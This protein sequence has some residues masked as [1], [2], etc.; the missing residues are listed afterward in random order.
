MRASFAGGAS[1]LHY[2]SRRRVSWLDID[3]TVS[4]RR[5]DVSQCN[6]AAIR[7]LPES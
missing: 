2:G 1:G 3:S 6:A 7:E 5:R 4:D